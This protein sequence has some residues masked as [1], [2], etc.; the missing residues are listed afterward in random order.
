[1]KW[2]Q[3]TLALLL[4][5]DVETALLGACLR[6]GGPAR[7]EWERW[8]AA[9][10]ADL[11]LPEQLSPARALLPLL[12]TS[13]AAHG[14]RMDPATR[15]YLHAG[16]LR[17][18][19]RARRYRAIVA[20]A[21]SALGRG[22]L[23]VLVT[24][25]AA[26]AATVYRE[27]AHR[28]CH[29]LDLL[30]AGPDVAG[31]AGALEHI[32]WKRPHPHDPGRGTRLRHDSG[33]EAALHTAVFEVPYYA[34]PPGDFASG[35]G[36]VAFDGVP[37][38]I[39]SAESTLIHVLGHAASSSSR[40]SLRW[41]TDAWHLL[42]ARK[43]LRW[44]EVVA[45][46]AAYRL[47]LPGSVMLTYLV[48][49]GAPVPAGSLASLAQRAR[50]ADR[51][52]EDVAVAGTY[53]GTGGDLRRLWRAQRSWRGRMGLA[54]WAVAPSAGYVR[55]EFAPRR[56]WLLPLCYVYRPARYVAGALAGPPERSSGLRD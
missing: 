5:S 6:T 48:R 27:P 37:A 34:A 51:I 35:G 47:A 24:R 7:D 1:M 15:S 55:S 25:G 23:T 44:T 26:L 53:R 41:V 8:R 46:L 16:A 4:P 29:D 20:E 38:R 54:R 13:A 17:E 18:D 33:L 21:L 10:R 45:R 39:P 56:D 31:V 49:L 32:G 52:E 43:D 3:E 9:Q 42:A 11:P 19:L 30:V 14:L 28:H 22:G 36:T 50:G 12:A 40:R 2:I